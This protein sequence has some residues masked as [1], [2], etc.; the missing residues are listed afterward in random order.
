MD[1]IFGLPLYF[2]YNYI[3]KCFVLIDL[4]VGDLTH[5]DLRQKRIYVHYY[6]REL[7]NE[8][9]NPPI[10]IVLCADKSESVVTVYAAGK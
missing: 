5:Q 9:D 10:G 3:F 4:K 2:I 6:E 1:D 7:T 8:G